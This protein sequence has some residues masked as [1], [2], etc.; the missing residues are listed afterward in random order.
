[1][2]KRLGAKGI[3]SGAHRL[4]LRMSATAAVLLLALGPEKVFALQ[5][6]LSKNYGPSTFVRIDSF[7][8]EKVKSGFIPYLVTIR[9]R[10]KRAATWT[11]HF[12]NSDSGG[13]SGQHNSRFK[14]R[15][16]P[17]AEVSQEV[18]VSAPA[19]GKRGPHSS[20]R[21][22]TI[23]V[24][25]PGLQTVQ[26]VDTH[27]IDEAWPSIAMS[28]RLGQRNLSRL[29]EE[30]KRLKG[31]EEFFASPFQQLPANWKGFTCLDAL[32]I[33]EST[34]LGLTKQQRSAAMTWV[35]FGG[36]LR[37]YSTK[38]NASLEMMELAPAEL[39]VKSSAKSRYGLG[40]VEI[41]SWN[42]ADLPDSLVHEYMPTPQFSY[43]LD[44]DFGHAW[45]MISVFGTKNFN[46]FLVLILL[47][48]F[49][50]VV[51]PVNLFHFAKPGRRHRMFVTTPL[52]SLA[53]TLIIFFIIMVQDGLGGKGRRI[54]FVEV[55]S[56]PDFRQMQVLQ[57]QISRTGVIL[58]GGFKNKEGPAIAP[59]N[60]PPTH[61]NPLSSRVSRTSVY[62]FGG[63]EYWGDF[64]RSRYEQGFH[65]RTVR[66]TRSRIE[67]KAKGSDYSPPQLF[68]SLEFPL[69]NLFYVDAG[70]VVWKS[71]PESTVEPG[72]DISLQKSNLEE[73]TA[74]M[75]KVTDTVGA[76][77]QGRI[78]E[79]RRRPRRFFGEARDPEELLIS[80]H[81]SIRWKDDLVLVSGLSVDQ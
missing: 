3:G 4:A 33:D 10:T 34:W 47:I 30:K 53:A 43:S 27:M 49:A 67:R 68:S 11:I 8:G 37:I 7:F 75:E 73:L 78:R 44:V 64:F 57:H 38:E 55:V 20:H 54:G 48:I 41:R 69:K 77:E 36:A 23:T 22:S 13:G 12:E 62:Q 76:T 80:T 45:K 24:S 70:G 60:L 61:W 19:S 21:Y 71:S 59:V 35:R 31:G 25:S 79:L 26:H 39:T 6:L 52:I 16:E 5:T 65:L 63:D 15:V 17:G 29:G 58:R 81:S 46:P 40:K 66:P 18:Y 74:W 51:G 1:M 50:V 32:L 2:T 9:N 28:K 14:I 72:R 56:H 42:G